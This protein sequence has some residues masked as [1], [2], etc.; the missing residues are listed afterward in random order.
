MGRTELARVVE[1]DRRER[2]DVLYE[3]HGSQLVARHGNWSA[4]AWDPEGHGE[5]SVEASAGEPVNKARVS[6]NAGSGRYL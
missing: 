6:P 3:Q 5:Y 1:I 4:S 2:I